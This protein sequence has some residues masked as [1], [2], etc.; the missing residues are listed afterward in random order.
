MNKNLVWIN[1]CEASADAYGAILMKELQKRSPGIE[2]AGMGGPAMR[3]AGLDSVFKAEDLSIVGFTEVFSSLPRIFG[4]LRAIKKALR[5]KR[6]AA[7]ILMDA[8]D[9]NFRLARMAY[10]LGIPVMYYIAPQVWAW[11]KSR[12]NFLKKYVDRIACIFPFEQDFFREHGIKADFV[13]HPVMEM[14]NL[15]EL[16]KITPSPGNIAILP[17]S[18]KKEISSLLK[19]FSA[20][21]TSLRRD[22]QSMTFNVIQAPGISRSY[23]NQFCPSKPWF[24]YIPFEKRYEFIRKSNMAIAASGTVTLECAILETPTIVA[25]RLSPMS[26]LLGRML[27]HVK[28]ISMANLILKKEVFPEFI[29]SEASSENLAEAVRT[30]IKEPHKMDEVKQSLKEVVRLLGKTSATRKSADIVFEMISK[31]KKYAKN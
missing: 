5:E 9:F 6:P 13:G 22:N 16:R 8:P 19:D 11:R 25:Y 12:V 1:V 26:Y 31:G 3:S 21:A 30:W 29:Q 20:A 24:R 4:Y 2:I 17:G 27:I 23:L 28:H 18:R 14:L 10:Y 15:A 7:L